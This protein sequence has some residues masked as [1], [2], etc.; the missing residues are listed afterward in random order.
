MKRTTKNIEDPSSPKRRRNAPLQSEA[1]Q[2]WEIHDS[3]RGHHPIEVKLPDFALR[4]DRIG[5]IS[6]IY[7]QSSTLRK[8]KECDLSDQ[9]PDQQVFV[10]G[11]IEYPRNDLPSTQRFRPNR[12]VHFLLPTLSMTT[13]LTF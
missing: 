5:T 10:L 7:P 13:L 9:R 12:S 3:T 2:K 11:R 4:P 6:L 8:R 1:P